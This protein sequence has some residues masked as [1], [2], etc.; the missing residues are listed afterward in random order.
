[1]TLWLI[2]PA[3]T[4]GSCAMAVRSPLPRTAQDHTLTLMKHPQFQ[5]AAA[6]APDFVKETFRVIRD[7]ETEAA[8]RR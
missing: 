4:L 8:N 5:R 1:M 7:L 2:V 3:L 6:A